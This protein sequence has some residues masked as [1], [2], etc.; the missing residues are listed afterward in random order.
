MIEMQAKQ[1]PCCGGTAEILKRGHRK[2][3]STYSVRCKECG[4]TKGNYKSE[5][6]AVERWNTRKGE[7][8]DWIPCSEVLP[9]NDTNVL[10]QW[11]RYY[12]DE[13][14]IDI[15]AL[16]A[17]G[18]WYCDLGCINGKAIVWKPLPEPYKEG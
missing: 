13:M 15:L 6:V 12:S 16:N 14:H 11:K 7:E 17:H 5:E 10:V 2:H 3:R 18:E 1:C 9:E 4:L 8:S